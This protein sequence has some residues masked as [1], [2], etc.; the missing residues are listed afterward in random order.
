MRDFFVKTTPRL[1]DAME[2]LK[3]DLVRMTQKKEAQK[4]KCKTL[5][6]SYQA[7]LKEKDNLIEI[8]ESRAVEMMERQ[9]DLLSP[10]P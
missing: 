2:V 7:D 6:I 9:G 8:L 1:L 4:T 10:N 5:E 3:L